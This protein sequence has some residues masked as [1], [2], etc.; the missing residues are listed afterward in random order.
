VRTLAYS[1]RHLPARLGRT[2]RCPRTVAARF[3]QA[4]AAASRKGVLDRAADAL[5]P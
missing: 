2:T 5:F 3:A 1:G 4:V